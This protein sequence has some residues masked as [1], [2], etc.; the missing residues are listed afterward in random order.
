MTDSSYPDINILNLPFE[1]REFDAVV[2]DQVLEHVEGNPYNAINET[3][4]VLKKDGIAL[5]TTCFFMPIH[6]PSDYWRFTPEALRL[7]VSKHGEI[8]DVGGWG[9]PYVWLFSALGLRSQPIPHARWHPAHWIATKNVYRWPIVTW[10]F[11]R[12]TIA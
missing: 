4:R 10:V 8:I 6:T 7:L 1:D 11:A 2:S 3:F 5:H 12:R 9:N